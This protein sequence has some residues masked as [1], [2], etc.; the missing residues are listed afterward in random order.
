M[1]SSTNNGLIIS[2]TGLGIRND[3]AGSGEHGASRGSRLHIGTDFLCKPGQPVVAPISGRVLRF[4]KP[5]SSGEYS[6]ISIVSKTMNV[7]LFYLAPNKSLRG[8][9]VKQGDLI[10]IAQDITER[11]PNQGMKPHIHFQ[12]DSIDPMALLKKKEQISL[13]QLSER[14]TALE[15][16]VG[17]LE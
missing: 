9:D 8:R 3:S 13:Q 2:P 16:Q 10:G 14:L 12:V 1:S 11:Y 7:K 5:Y 17:K 15:E 4:P 6:G